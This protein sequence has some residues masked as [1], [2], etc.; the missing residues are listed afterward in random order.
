MN[1]RPS[2]AL[3]GDRRGRVE[4]IAASESSAAN[5]QRPQ[6][7]PANRSSQSAASP[8]FARDEP[9]ND[10]STFQQFS[11]RTGTCFLWNIESFLFLRR[12]SK[13]AVASNVWICGED[14]ED[15]YDGDFKVIVTTSSTPRGKPSTPS[16]ERSPRTFG[17]GPL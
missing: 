12:R 7:A 16:G 13:S 5:D 1:G 10:A 9:R 14:D 6:T 4:R 15:S 11:S 3:P 2:S 8:T 17:I